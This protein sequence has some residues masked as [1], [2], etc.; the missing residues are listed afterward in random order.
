MCH[1]C[2]KGVVTNGVTKISKIFVFQGYQLELEDA[3]TDTERHKWPSPSPHGLADA[4]VILVILLTYV[5]TTPKETD[6][7]SFIQRQGLPTQ[8]FCNFRSPLNLE[9]RGMPR[10]NHANACRRMMDVSKEG[11]QTT[12]PIKENP[13][14]GTAKHLPEAM[15]EN[16][17]NS[18]G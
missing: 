15:S 18:R 6:R 12:M 13:R 4:F 11:H 5:Q 2:L 17:R 3:D 16:F 8:N 10:Y 7:A 9:A 14:W 1:G